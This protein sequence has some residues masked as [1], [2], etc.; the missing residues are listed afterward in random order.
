MGSLGDLARRGL[1]VILDMGMGLVSLD[2]WD[3][4]RIGAAL[5]LRAAMLIAAPSAAQTLAE[6]Q[7]AL[8][9]GDATAAAQIAEGLGGPDVDLEAAAFF[10]VLLR[11][12]RDVAQDVPRAMDLL[13]RAAE[14]GSVSAL[15]ALG[16]AWQE[17]RPGLPAD[18][19]QAQRAYEAAIA[20]GSVAAR[21]NLAALILSGALGPPDYTALRGLV[22]QAVDGGSAAA[23]V[24]MAGLLAQGLGGPADPRRAREM[25][26]TAYDAGAP[27]AARLLAQM[28]LQGVGGRADRAAA[29]ATLEAAF[30]AGDAAAG[31][32]L[33]TIVP[34]P[35]DA[36][37]WLA[38]AADAGD[39]QAAMVLARQ[40]SDGALDPEDDLARA[41]ALYRVAHERGLGAGSYALA[42][43]LWDGIGVAPDPDAARAVMEIAAARSNAAAMND[44]GV[45]LETGVGSAADV[46]AARLAYRASA[47]AGHGLGAWNLAD[48]LLSAPGGG[49]VVE[50]YAWCLR[51]IREEVDPVLR[52]RFAESCG[53]YAQN[54]TPEMI[55][56]AE[57]L[58][59][60]MLGDPLLGG[61]DDPDGAAQTTDGDAQ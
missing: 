19:V 21:A 5:A 26:Q 56:D 35:Q 27:G 22:A 51:A 29:Q 1:S 12:G 45:M 34:D 38:R 42:L 53:G 36:V 40:L 57:A 24:Q 10:A 47:E 7:E 54:L 32:D 37:N 2:L 58:V 55:A 60:Q 6:A 33:A 20:Q 61:E 43:N 28:Q 13:Q 3:A 25:A 39:G 50:G 31:T 52:V 17:G 49:E 15:V 11:D 46:S 59:A 44:L 14:A 4:R 30:V 8:S 23:Q 9:A 48:L 18:P 16:R 41:T